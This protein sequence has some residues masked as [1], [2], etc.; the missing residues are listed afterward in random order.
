MHYW[1]K[2][3]KFE[4]TACA[5]HHASSTWPVNNFKAS[6]QGSGTVSY[7]AAGREPCATGQW[8]D[9]GER[10]KMYSNI[11]NICYYYHLATC[12]QRLQNSKAWLGRGH[13]RDYAS[14]WQLHHIRSVSDLWAQHTNDLSNKNWSDIVSH[15]DSSWNTNLDF[16]PSEA[17]RKLWLQVQPRVANLNSSR[18]RNIHCTHGRFGVV[19]SKQLLLLKLRMQT[20]HA[21]THAWCLVNRWYRHKAEKRSG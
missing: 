3:Y 4:C 21:R 17:V 12:I 8:T 2:W 9:E 1:Q 13:L 19:D 18:E 15:P 6:I 20:A 10:E 16:S 5:L 14:N 7:R 11:Y